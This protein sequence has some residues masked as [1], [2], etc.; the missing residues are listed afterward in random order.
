MKKNRLI[1]AIVPIM[2]TFTFISC[3]NSEEMPQ[4]AGTP[5]NEIRFAA[6]TEYS[7][8]TDI[9]TSNLTTFNVYAYTGTATNP[10][11][12]MNN[13]KVSKTAS[14]TW[15]YS[16]V[17]YW[18]AD[19]EV[20][21][22]AFSPASWVGESSPLSPVPYD[23]FALYPSTE[24]IVYAVS[25]NL[26]GY[27][28]Q[29][30]AQVIFNFRHALSKITLKMRSSSTDLVVRITNVALTNIMTQGNFLFPKASTAGTLSAENVGKW[31]DQNTPQSYVLHISQD[32]TDMIIL[33]PTP[34]VIEPLG[35][36][37][38]GRLFVMPQ[39]LTWRRNGSGN[40]TYL[41][42]MCVIYDRKS[43]EKIWPNKNTP[44]ENVVSGST[45]GDGLLKFPLSTSKFSEWQPG[46]HYIYNINI[47]S[48]EE[49]GS[50]EFGTP[51]VDSFIEV[52]TNY[53]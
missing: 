19:E 21:F 26:H 1:L 47:S 16:P 10:K 34:V 5:D 3:S 4:P 42:V 43:G 28:G 2:A 44:P 32:T 48:N 11:L 41:V 37:M 31:A 53:E 24:D 30:N 45:F 22:Y 40:D 17:Q 25:P 8:G 38:G 12:F 36:G 9:T 46:C 20:D 50:I 23:A 33:N 13:V 7:R 52:E 6:N 18:P 49:M 15:G 27:A 51:T 39:H 14:N 35:A 29:A